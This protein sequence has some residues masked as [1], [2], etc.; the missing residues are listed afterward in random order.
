MTHRRPSSPARR[1]PGAGFTVIELV[2]VIVILGVLAV[3]V[4]PSFLGSS[5][6]K[7]AGL[8]DQ[9]VTALR[10]AQKAALSHRRLVCAAV[11]ANGVK[12]TIAQ[13][14]G[15]TSCNLE[16]AGPGGGSRMV[17][18]SAGIGLASS[19]ATLFFQPSGQVTS[20]G[21]GNNPATFS[22]T[23]SGLKPISVD[24]RTGYAG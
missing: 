24:G 3:S 20:D 8:R 14:G 10:Y 19:A 5:D 17:T 21:A 9:V 15:A 13:N 11:D 22:I 2:V 6:I 4:L 1:L 7:S 12:L 23:V 16:L 18:N